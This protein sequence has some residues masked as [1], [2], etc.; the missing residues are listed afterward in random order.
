MA[1]AK[2]CGLSTG[3]TLDAALAGGAAFVG[4]VFFPASP[5]YVSLTTAQTLATRARGRAG[6]VAVTVDPDDDLVDSLMA[7]LRPDFLQLHGHESPERVREIAR[8][9]GAGII[10]AIP[11]LSQADLN[12]A[13]AYDDQ[14]DHLMFDAK[15]S[16]TA[17]RPGGL[18]EAFDWSI[19]A[20]A[21]FRRPW[22]LAAG[23]N[24]T[25]VVAAVAT[26]GAPIV[27]VSSG[28]ESAPGLKEPALI[29]RFLAA[30]DRS[31]A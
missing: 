30:I 27:D 9:S 22:F 18:G 17:P 1:L 15:A 21:R 20:G 16:A 5:R 13:A 3:P 25:N 24:P 19:L 6:I 28:V 12:I 23:L 7:E 14:V 10:K 26:S 31:A 4:F 8:R 2:I 29:T 11:V